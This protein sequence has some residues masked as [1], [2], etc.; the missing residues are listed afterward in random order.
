MTTRA[1]NIFAVFVLLLPGSD[2]DSCLD[3]DLQ[4][5]IHLQFE[6]CQR[7]KLNKENF[8]GSIL[9]GHIHS[10]LVIPLATKLLLRT[11]VGRLESLLSMLCSLFNTEIDILYNIDIDMG[12]ITN[13]SLTPKYLDN[14]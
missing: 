9:G 10:C 13:Y 2:P 5:Q 6:E 4:L 1:S 7:N 3:P 14:P 12:S 11:S 8:L